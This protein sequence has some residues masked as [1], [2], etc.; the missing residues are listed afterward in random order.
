LLL[1]RNRWHTQDFDWPIRAAVEGV[2][3]EMKQR[4]G[5]YRARYLGLV[6]VTLE[7]DLVVLAFNLK[8]AA[9]TH[10]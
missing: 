5:L 2:F 6:K 10:R 8:T 7:C 9:L 3:G 4:L 1:C